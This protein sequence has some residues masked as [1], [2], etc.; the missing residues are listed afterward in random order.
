LEGDFRACHSNLV[1]HSEEIAFYKGN[2]WEEERLN[3]TF[4]VI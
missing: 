2:E 4:N 3:K 1:N